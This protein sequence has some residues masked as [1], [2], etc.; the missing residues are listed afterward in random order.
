MCDN[1]LLTGS[2]ILVSGFVA[3]T[4][5]ELSAYHWQILTYLAWF[6]G[7]THIS[8]LIFLRKYFFYNQVQ[9]NFRLFF[10]FLHAV[11]VAIALI[12]TGW[13]T[14]YGRHAQCFWEQSTYKEVAYNGKST[15][16]N[17][18]IVSIILLF[19][20][21]SMRTIEVS[22]WASSKLFFEW[23]K[24]ISNFVTNLLQRLSSKRHK[25][26][27]RWSAYFATSL[28]LVF[29]LYLDLYVSMLAK[30]RNQYPSCLG[31]Y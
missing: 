25:W 22:P 8:G 24:M 11:C 20:N 15:E 4:H 12:P 28:F 6:S 31:Y 23:R 30:V 26:Y 14:A 9:R 29:R 17:S 10:M 2:G 13:P 18:M 7:L 1:Q 27:Y 16:F 21:L 19:F 5:D 3:M